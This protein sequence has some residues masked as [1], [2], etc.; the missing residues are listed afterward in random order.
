VTDRD[1]DGFVNRHG[2][3]TDLNRIDLSDV[4]VDQDG[5]VH[6]AAPPKAENPKPVRTKRRFVW[7]KRYTI[8]IAAVVA[9]LILIP[10]LAGES[11][12]VRYNS[13]AGSV[14]GRLEK[15]IR[16]KVLPSQKQTTI[17]AAAIGEMASAVNDIRS[18][19]CA[20]GLLDNMAMLYP[21]AKSAHEKCIAKAEQ[22]SALSGGLRQLES[23]TRYVESVMAATKTITAPLSE[24]YA[25]MSAQHA[26]WQAA[27]D[28]VNKLHAPNEW[29]EQHTTLVRHFSAIVEAWSSLNTAS[30]AQDRTKF[31]QAEK[32]LNSGYEG[33]R[34]TVS[35]LVTTLNA[36]Q[37]NVTKSYKNL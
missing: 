20:G 12:V 2:H 3:R 4:S 33:V 22:L 34:T 16:D 23:Q 19:I 1:K 25:V 14:D 32:A 9:A 18:S 21:R 28:A 7:R 8:T 11:L 13:G 6:S 10:V 26:N 24:P 31:E 17:K 29:A 5:D 36:T 37:T 30:D 35:E 27:R 15:L